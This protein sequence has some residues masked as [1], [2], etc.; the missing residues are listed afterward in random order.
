MSELD[1]ALRARLARGEVVT[2]TQPVPGSKTPRL[3]LDAMVSAA[4]AKVW[5]VIDDGERYQDFMPRVKASHVLRR[6]GGEVRSR[7]TVAMP[8]PLKDLSA[9]TDAVHEVDEEADRYVRRWTLR[10]GDYKRNEGSW[11][12]R[13]FNEERTQTWVHYELHV[14]PKIRIPKKIAAAA[15]G[16]AMPALI[17]SIRQ[18][19]RQLG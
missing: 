8:F 11:T 1:P 13:P 14:E 2:R 12:L 15:Q 7:V 9:V 5:V 3:I 16:K 10:E 17:D 18:R 6:E 19:V 4:P